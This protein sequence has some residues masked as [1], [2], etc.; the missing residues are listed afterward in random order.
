MALFSR[1]LIP[2]G[3]TLHSAID[4]A[5][6]T[7]E[8][9]EEMLQMTTKQT[10]SITSAVQ[11]MTSAVETSSKHVAI[12]VEEA[13]CA[14]Y[15]A[16]EGSI[17]VNEMMYGIE[18]ITDAV[19]RVSE[20]ITALSESSTAIGDMAI[21][22]AEVADRTNLLA[23]NAAIEAARAGT[24]GRG[25]AVVADEVRQLAERTQTATKE[26]TRTIKKIQTQIAVAIKETS[27]VRAEIQERRNDATQSRQSLLSIIERINRV[28]DIIQQISDNNEQQSRIMATVTDSV[29]S[30]ISITEH[31]SI[32]MGETA[33]GIQGIESMI[34]NLVKLTAGQFKIHR[35][36]GNR[37]N[38]VPSS[39]VLSPQD[40]SA[41]SLS[42]N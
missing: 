25:F 16:H 20:V 29:K 42:L 35:N 19:T 32:T 10:Q 7:E 39:V 23:L 36:A 12:A 13:S 17:S 40:I 28:G 2:G 22:I 9:S 34:Q 3:A 41:P 15:A 11:Q 31:T 14:K 18:S 38:N 26:I 30:I 21:M 1:S 27:I 33:W 4:L 8:L 6:R 37:L 5:K 24:H